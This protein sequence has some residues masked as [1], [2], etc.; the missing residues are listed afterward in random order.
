MLTS[1]LNTVSEWSASLPYQLICTLCGLACT[2]LAMRAKVANF[3]IGYLYN[4]LLFPLFLQKG[5][6][7]SMMLQPVSFAINIFGHY[8]WTHPHVNEA[9]QKNELKITLL[10][11][12]Q[13]VFLVL[14]IAASTVGLWGAASHIHTWF[15]GIPEAHQTFLD[16]FVLVLIFTAQWLS[17]QKKLDCW[18]AW[19]TV[20]VA[21]A[22]RFP[23]ISLPVIAVE[24]LAKIGMASFGFVHWLKKYRS[25]K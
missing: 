7:F 9:T 1:F 25:E 19:M 13:R 8:R 5:L 20:N 14:L 15:P 21:N 18:A 4:I 12:R 23:L 22:I 10:S 3:W 16:A 17:A 2:F 11:N 24:Y 6:Y